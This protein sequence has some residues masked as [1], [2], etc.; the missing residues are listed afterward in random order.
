MTADQ[1][2]VNP[3]DMRNSS[4]AHVAN[5]RRRLHPGTWPFLTVFGKNDPVLGSADEVLQHHVPGTSGQPHQRI[6]GG[7]FIQEDRGD[8]L[9]RIVLA[10]LGT[11]FPKD[12]R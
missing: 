7:H 6:W 9:A 10:W 8:E 5:E 12:I 3:P 11:S 2:F 1:A 4:R